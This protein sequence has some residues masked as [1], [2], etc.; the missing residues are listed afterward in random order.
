MEEGKGKG[1]GEGEADAGAGAGEARLPHPKLKVVPTPKLPLRTLTTLTLR[2]KTAP[3]K[4]EA[5]P[6]FSST[7][8]H[9]SPHHHQVNPLEPRLGSPVVAKPYS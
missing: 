5:R 6:V 2:Q 1:K 4:A 7:A 3:E 8:N 9:T